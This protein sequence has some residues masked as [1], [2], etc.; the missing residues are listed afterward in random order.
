MAG[1]DLDPYSQQHGAEVFQ[2]LHDY[3][4]AVIKMFLCKHNKCWETIYYREKVKGNE[5]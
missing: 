3:R 4:D 5:I 1:A 2:L